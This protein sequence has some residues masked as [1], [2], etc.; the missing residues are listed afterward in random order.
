M[1]SKVKTVII[2][3]GL[4]VKMEDV[5]VRIVNVDPEESEVV[6]QSRKVLA[7]NS[8]EGIIT[9]IARDEDGD[10]LEGAPVRLRSDSDHSNIEHSTIVT[11]SAGV[12]RFKV[13]SG[14]S[15]AVNLYA[16]TTI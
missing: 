13:Q 9:V 16:R 8:A 6:A 11:K 14:Q 2:T 5:Y 4:G 7:N 10:E 1:V 3:V 15:A 12:A